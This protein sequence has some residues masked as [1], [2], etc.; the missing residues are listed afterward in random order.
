MKG[1]RKA[2]RSPGTVWAML[3]IGTFP[4][5]FVRTLEDDKILVTYHLERGDMQFIRLTRRHA[6]LLAKRINEC[7]DD[8]NK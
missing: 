8:T 6:R 2:N 7:L 4:N 1:L 3:R 5:G